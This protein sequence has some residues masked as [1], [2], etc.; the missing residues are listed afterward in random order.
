MYLLGVSST[1][2]PILGVK[3]SQNPNFGGVNKH[4]QAK[5]A[6]YLKFHVIETTALIVTKF[7]VTIKTIEWSSWVVPVGAQQIQDG[8]RPPF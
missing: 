4:F 8:G 1:L 6:K 2:L 3:Y 7:G 5:W